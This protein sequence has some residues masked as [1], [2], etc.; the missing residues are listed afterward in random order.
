MNDL[1]IEY[2]PLSEL[3]MYKNNS[4]KHTA[5]QIDQICKSITELGFRD[6]IEISNGVIVAGHG[7]YM[8]AKKLKLDL[9]P[10]IRHDDLT[11]DEGKAYNLINNRLTLETDFDL[12]LLNEE[13]QSLNNFDLSDYGLEKFSI[14][15]V[16]AVDSFDFEADTSEYFSAA[17]TFPTAKKEKILKYLRLH[18]QEITDKIIEECEVI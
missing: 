17:F 13:I 14:D 15:E 1:K 5:R 6:P 4:K 7:R 8:A 18:K 9:V 16:Q 3:K 11:E 12:S 10:V 2:L